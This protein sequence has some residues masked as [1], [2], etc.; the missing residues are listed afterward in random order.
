M[1]VFVYEHVTANG[2]GRDP[3]SPWHSL[4]IEGNAMLAAV[5]DDFAAVPGVEVLLGSAGEFDVLA[6]TANWSFVIA[7]ESD[8]ILAELY[9]RVQQLGGRWL[10]C[11]APAIVLATDK[12]ALFQHWQSLKL[13][14]PET[15]RFPKRPS[16]YPAVMKRRDGCGSD[17]TRLIRTEWDWP[18]ETD[19]WIAQPFI[20]GQPA[21]VAFLIGTNQTIA[22]PPTFQ[23]ISDDGQFQ[24]RGGS[25]PIPADLEARA[26]ALARRGI[27]SLPGLFGFVGVDLI[28]GDAKEWLL[29]INPRLTTSYVGLRALAK[30]N[31]VECLLK[32]AGGG[33]ASIEWNEGIQIEF[34][35][36]GSV[37]SSLT[38]KG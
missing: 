14:T 19:G 1:K 5:R 25:L 29:E 31:L 20:A 9:R 3:A 35:A 2:I 21:S 4:Y 38:P 17:G 26:E 10:G 15:V 11:S 34:A 24:Y 33:S 18:A 23:S 37:L 6:T 22:L 12:I 16:R 8:G 36:D 13:P 30:S 7:P 32:L 27:E 28:L